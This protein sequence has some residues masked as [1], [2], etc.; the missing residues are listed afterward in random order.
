MDEKLTLKENGLRGP[1]KEVR[2]YETRKKYLFFGD[3]VKSVKVGHLKFD[4]TDHLLYEFKIL[5]KVDSIASEL[6]VFSALRENSYNYDSNWRLLSVD[7]KYSDFDILPVDSVFQKTVV[8][9]YDQQGRVSEIVDGEN[10][11][12]NTYDEAGHVAKQVQVPVGDIFFFSYDAEGRVIEE[13]EKGEE[14]EL[15]NKTVYEYDRLG[16]LVKEIYYLGDETVNSKF[17]FYSEDKYKYNK[18]GDLEVAINKFKSDSLKNRYSY[19]YDS[20]GNWVKQTIE[21]CEGF[22]DKVKKT[23]VHLREIEYFQ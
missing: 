17:E 5:H 18:Y 16:Q 3:W 11:H 15:L 4:K 2:E 8:Y 13:T 9:N 1:V 23:T 22:E 7:S 6:M 12:V 19:E 10:K 14:G 20:Y 21:E